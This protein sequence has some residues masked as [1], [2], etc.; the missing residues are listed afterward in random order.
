MPTIG[1]LGDHR[2]DEIPASHRDLVQCPP[3]AALTTVM[4]DGSPQASVVWCDFDGVCVRVN[5]MRGLPRSATCAP[6][7][8]SPT[9]L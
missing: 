7:P 5:T 1:L 8:E 6:T 4:P 2:V 9:V 3:V